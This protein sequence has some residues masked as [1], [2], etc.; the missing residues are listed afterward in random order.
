MRTTSDQCIADAATTV[1]TT[2]AEGTV[3]C[4]GVVT[5]DYLTSLL[6]AATDA[7]AHTPWTSGGTEYH[8]ILRPLLPDRARVLRSFAQYQ[9]AEGSVAGPMPG[10]HSNLRPERKGA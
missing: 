9:R 5:G 7:N 8:L 1:F 2:T 4:C 10:R 6:A 3:T